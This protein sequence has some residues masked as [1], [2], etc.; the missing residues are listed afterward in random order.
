MM[1][2]SPSSS[3]HLTQ[4]LQQEMQLH[5]L[6]FLPE[7]DVRRMAQVNW[8]FRRLVLKSQG[9]CHLWKSLVCQRWPYLRAGNEDTTPTQLFCAVPS[10]RNLSHLLRRGATHTPTAVDQ[11]LL[12]P[13]LQ[14]VNDT[15]QLLL[16]LPEETVCFTGRVGRGA[17]SLRANQPLPRP[18]TTSSQDKKKKRSIWQC[19]CRGRRNIEDNR[20]PFVVP[21]CIGQGRYSATPR[22]IAYY[23]VNVLEP[24]SHIKPL[25]RQQQQARRQQVTFASGMTECVAVGL[26]TR[27]FDIHQSL[28]GWGEA[29]VGYHSDDNTTFSKS[30]AKE[31]YGPRFGPGDVVGCGI[32][33]QAKA[34]FFTLNGK[35]LGYAGDLTDEDLQQ[36]WYPT[37]GLDSHAAVQCNFGTH[38]PF[39][40]DLVAMVEARRGPKGTHRPKVELHNL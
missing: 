7:E 28:P 19:L 17:R 2:Q 35:F 20:R 15:E 33:Y 31:N 30:Q 25:Q 18:L 23:E 4:M 11:V 34:C 40:Y 12:S 8:H 38:R 24:P 39:L 6:G 26:G 32:D 21:F 14:L 29:S 1:M 5:V 22:W 37:V 9:G 36:D 13:K 16:L 3:P 27:F 10:R